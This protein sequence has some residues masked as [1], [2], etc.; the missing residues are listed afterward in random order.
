MKMSDCYELYQKYGALSDQ[1]I[2]ELTSADF[3]RR[4]QQQEEQEQKDEESE[5]KNLHEMRLRL[6]R[7]QTLG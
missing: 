4:A 6:R 5:E 2:A 3:Q 7:E 1:G